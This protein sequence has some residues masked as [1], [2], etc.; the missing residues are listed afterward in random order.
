MGGYGSGRSAGKDTTSDYLC[1][2]GRQWQWRG[3]WRRGW[4][5]AGGGHVAKRRSPASVRAP[6]LGGSGS[7][8]DPYPLRALEV[9][10][11][12]LDI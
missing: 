10:M 7:M 8:A 4:R 2:D 12:H 3:Y 1:L 6:K 5:L 9:A 11:L